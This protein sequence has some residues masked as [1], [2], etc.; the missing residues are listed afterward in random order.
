[1]KSKKEIKEFLDKE[2][3]WAESQPLPEALDAAMEVFDNS[4][5][6]PAYKKKVLER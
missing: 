5:V 4:V 6:E 3:D 1:M 2:A